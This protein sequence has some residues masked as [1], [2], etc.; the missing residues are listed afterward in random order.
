[1]TIHVEREEIIQ[2]KFADIDL[3]KG[4]GI[5]MLVSG[6]MTWYVEPKANFRL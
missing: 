6:N 3:K 4:D 2:Q 5:E 1:M